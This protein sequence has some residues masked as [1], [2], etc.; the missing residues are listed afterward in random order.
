MKHVALTSFLIPFINLF[1]FFFGEILITS[2][3]FL[4][5]GLLLRLSSI[6]SFSGSHFPVFSRIWD[7]TDQNNSEYNYYVLIYID[8]IT[9]E[10]LCT[11]ATLVS[12]SEQNK[13]LS[14]IFFTTWTLTWYLCSR[15]NAYFPEGFYPSLFMYPLFFENVPCPRENWLN[16]FT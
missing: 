9:M 11:Y 8:I 6:S 12:P 16:R 3:H 2:Y 13:H 4:L 14:T 5:S 15:L 1:F 7:N 10:K